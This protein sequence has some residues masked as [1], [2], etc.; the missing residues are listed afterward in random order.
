MLAS[1]RELVFE[2]TPDSSMDSSSTDSIFLTAAA[3]ICSGVSP[4]ADCDNPIDS[5]SKASSL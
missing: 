4:P 1:I 5:S 3:A 2:R